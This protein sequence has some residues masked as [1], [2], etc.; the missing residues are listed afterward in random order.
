[1]LKRKR[2][3]LLETDEDLQSVATQL[4]DL[5]QQQPNNFEKLFPS[6][7][8]LHRTAISIQEQIERYE[9]QSLTII[10]GEKDGNFRFII[11]LILVNYSILTGAMS[12]HFHP[13][14]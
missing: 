14:F 9:P 8:I 10:H 7:A 4:Q 1:M 13:A 5:F 3:P 6:F 11:V 12:T 2:V